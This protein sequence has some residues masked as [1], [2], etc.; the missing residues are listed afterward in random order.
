MKPVAWSLKMDRSSLRVN[1]PTTFN[2]RAWAEEYADKCAVPD[3]CIPNPVRPTVVALYHEEDVQSLQAER[4]SLR[5][6]SQA[7]DSLIDMLTKA[8]GIANDHVDGLRV[9]LEVIAKLGA[10]D[11]LNAKVIAR[12]ALEGDTTTTPERRE[13]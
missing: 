8:L 2:E 11:G 12:R 3:V 1:A 7:D 10:T 4:D 5:D 6:K 9:A 13:S